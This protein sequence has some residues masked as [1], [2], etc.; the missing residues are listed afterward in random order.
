MIHTVR[1][2]FAVAAMATVMVACGSGP[3]ATPAPVPA[4]PAQ[5]PSAPAVTLVS[6]QD[7]R[8]SVPQFSGWTRGEITAQE[9]PAPARSTHVHVTFTRGTETL[10]LEIADT[11]GDERSIE[12]LEHMAGSSTSRTVGNGYF[13]GTNVATFPAVESWNTVDK[14]GELS[15]LIRR[16]F[17][18]NV[19]GAGL[20]DAAPMRALAEAVD[21]SRLR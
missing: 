2:A 18:I 21:T 16:R 20:P 12:S 19:A 5:T 14:L 7:L 10:S 9:G 6:L 15:V 3:E 13:K 17:I 8:A 1:R 4:P 11:G